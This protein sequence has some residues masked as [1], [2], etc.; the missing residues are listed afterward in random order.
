M[1]T[2]ERERAAMVSRYGLYVKEKCDRCGK[3]V[4]QSFVYRP[5]GVTDSSGPKRNG[6]EKERVVYC[7]L[8]CQWRAYYGEE[9]Y[10][11]VKSKRQPPEPSGPKCI[12]CGRSIPSFKKDDSRYCS[13]RCAQKKRRRNPEN[14]KVR[15]N[16][17]VSH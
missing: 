3:L 17:S 10:E 12:E 15:E 1:L 9:K 16:R 8:E 6:L 11:R 4:Q 5:I 13:R 7:S 2:T 14:P